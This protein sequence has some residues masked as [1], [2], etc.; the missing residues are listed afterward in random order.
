MK[1]GCLFLILIVG[2]LF[3]VFFLQAILSG[4]SAA[5]KSTSDTMWVEGPDKR[6]SDRSSSKSTSDTMWVEGGNLHKA[7]VSEW[8]NANQQNRLATAADW[9]SATKWK[10]H[11]NSPTDFER[12][13]VK[14]QLLVDALAEASSG[15]SLDS[16][17]VNE[18]AASL[19]TISNDYGP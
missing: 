17:A 12:L 1:K 15:N 2:G 11:L 10:G 9:L 3:A 16:L 5:S 13:K 8:K 18:L 4:P 6:G 19:M 14:S 7:T